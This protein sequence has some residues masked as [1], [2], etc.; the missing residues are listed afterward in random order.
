MRRLP[1]VL[2]RLVLPSAGDRSLLWGGK[3]GGSGG[4][5]R[6]G[7]VGI[8]KCARWRRWRPV[9]PFR[10]LPAHLQGVLFVQEVQSPTASLVVL[11][12]NSSKT[13]PRHCTPC[14]TQGMRDL[15]AQG[16]MVLPEVPKRPGAKQGGSSETP[17]EY[18]LQVRIL[19]RCNAR[20]S[21]L[22]ELYLWIVL[23]CTAPPDP[24]KPMCSSS[25]LLPPKPLPL[26]A[27]ALSHLPPRTW[28]PDEPWSTSHQSFRMHTDPWCSSRWWRLTVSGLDP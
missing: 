1:P 13:Q 3:E 20:S 15:C 10:V 12:P 27:M 6:R 7:R 25:T 26:T 14:T 21:V 5:R 4:A 8:F 17:R 18:T 11:Y 22:W 24:H 16:E 23:C 2:P 19:H 9:V 28:I